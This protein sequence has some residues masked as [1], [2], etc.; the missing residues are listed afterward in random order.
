MMRAL[1]LLAVILL[2]LGLVSRPFGPPAAQELARVALVAM[3]ATLAGTFLWLWREKATPL[4]LAMTFSWAGASALMGWRLVQDLLG[5]PLWMGESPML[6]GVLGVYL[7]G[8]LLHVEAIRR[9]FGLG[10]V[11]LVFLLGGTLGA[12]VLVLGVLG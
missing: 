12:A 9:A 4:A 2:A 11:A 8:T 7:T 10:Q 5:H 6:L 3:A 1:G